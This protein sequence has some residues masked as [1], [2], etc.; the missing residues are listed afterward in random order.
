MSN[1][2]NLFNFGRSIPAPFDR[3]NKR[4]KVQSRYGDKGESTLC[5]NVVKAIMAFCA[6]ADGSGQGAVGTFEMSGTRCVAEYKSSAGPNSYHLVVYDMSSGSLMASVYE[7]DSESIEVYKL[8]AGNRD[9]AAVIFAMMPALLTDTEFSEKLDEFSQHKQN[10]FTDLDAATECLA[11]L[12]DNVYRRAKD[13][14]CGAHIKVELEPSG[15]LSKVSRT[16]LD[17]GKYTPQTVVAGEFSIFAKMG[18]SATFGKAEVI[19]EQKDFVG[20]FALHSRTFTPTEQALIPELPAWY[21]IPQE[22]V[23]VCKHAS[24]TTGKPTQMRNFLLRGPAGTG[25]TM[26]AKAIAAG[27]GLPYMKYT[28]SAQTEIYDFI[29]QIFPDSENASTGDATLDAEL[30]EL[31]AMGGITYPNV[32]K[33]MNLPGLDDMDYD[34]EGVYKA[35]TGTEKPGVKS[36]DCMEVVLKMVTEKVKALSKRVEPK[37][38]GGQSFSYVETDFIKALEHGYVVEIQEPTTIMQPGVLVG[39][40]SLLEQEGSITLPTGKVIKRHPDAVVVVTTNISYEGC[41]GMNQSIVDRMNLVKDVELPTP[42]VMV[43]RAMSVTGST[44]EYL[45]S[46]MVKVVNNMSEYCRKNAI[47][48][49]TVGMRSLLDWIV[50]SEITGDAYESALSTIISKATAVEEDRE[51]LIV[52]LEQEFAPKRRRSA[53]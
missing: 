19:I 42:E 50:S 25:K 21:V 27:L 45:V 16:Q 12:C 4:V 11:I 38:D 35:L 53:A 51:A 36:Q 3:V 52:I 1:I 31:K 47:T 20:K 17:A 40:N 30:K 6:C 18:A 34:P 8:D 37:K 44:D 23:D 24:V 48:D 43:Q 5:G 26:G 7:T 2:N 46:K 28:C 33:I 14:T 22:V 29:G 39:L 10:G 49:G 15:N 13:P 9:G 41:R 32:A